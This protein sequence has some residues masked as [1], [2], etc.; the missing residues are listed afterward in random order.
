MVSRSDALFDCIRGWPYCLSGGHGL[1]NFTKL[2]LYMCQIARWGAEFKGVKNNYCAHCYGFYNFQLWSI[3]VVRLL[4]CVVVR[5]V[6][7]CQKTHP[8]KRFMPQR[9]IV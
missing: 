4:P 3:T 6:K 5:A 2:A 7:I 9:L 8:F 1:V